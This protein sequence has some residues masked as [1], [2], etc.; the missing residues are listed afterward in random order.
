MPDTDGF[1]ESFPA[2]L[3]E[4]KDVAAVGDPNGLLS[5]VGCRK[6]DPEADAVC[7]I[8]YRYIDSDFSGQRS[9]T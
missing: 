5:V 8:G 9:K 3:P 1:P 6:K 4:E 7:F 2:E